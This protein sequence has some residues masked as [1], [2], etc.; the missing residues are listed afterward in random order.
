MMNGPRYR[1]LAALAV[2]VT[3]LTAVAGVVLGTTSAG[4]R[5]TPAVAPAAVATHPADRA[6]LPTAPAAVE[7]AFPSSVEVGRSHVAVLADG[8]S[9]AGAGPLVQ[10]A[11][12][13]V[14][15]PVAITGP[16]T[17]TA[18]YHV[19]FADGT[20]GSGFLRFSV[21]TGVPPPPLDAAA[22][23]RAT[24]AAAA[25]HPHSVDPLSAGL[26]VLDGLVAV[27]VV[28]LLLRR[29]H[30]DKRRSLFV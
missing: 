20:E 2:A 18:A 16:G 17:F 28:A 7:L 14:R 8:G 15:Q 24:D 19:T 5:A 23:D 30:I 29:P 6:A 12:G 4:S 9:Q 25:G 1:R 3:G 26:L 13:T 22:A 11:P 10:L 27:A 21:G